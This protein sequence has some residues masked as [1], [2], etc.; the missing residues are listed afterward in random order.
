MKL[1]VYMIDVFKIP[2]LIWSIHI[3][4]YFNQIYVHHRSRI[5]QWLLHFSQHKITVN[6]VKVTSELKNVDAQCAWIIST[7]SLVFEPRTDSVCTV[8][9]AYTETKS[10]K[11]KSIHGRWGA[12]KEAWLLPKR[13]CVSWVNFVCL[14]VHQIAVGD[15]GLLHRTRAREL[16]SNLG[17]FIYLFS[18]P[19]VL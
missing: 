16:H 15:H 13:P 5:L 2:N 4:V 14:P 19:Q 6:N 7:P 9:P 10:R 12:K 1:R 11:Q 8:D 18:A 17:K 3:L